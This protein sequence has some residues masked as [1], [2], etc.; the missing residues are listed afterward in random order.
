MACTVAAVS[1]EAEAPPAASVATERPR[2]S[3]ITLAWA[4]SLAFAEPAALAWAR[5]RSWRMPMS[6]IGRSIRRPRHSKTP[7]HL[8]RPPRRARNRRS[9]RAAHGSPGVAE[10][11]ARAEI[12]GR[13]HGAAGRWRRAPRH[14]DREHDGCDDEGKLRRRMRRI[15]FDFMVV[16]SLGSPR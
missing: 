14:G 16:L 12:A 13:T 5:A 2:A 7:R 8:A 4:S 11:D 1:S 3:P 9:T 10:T 6:H 15:G